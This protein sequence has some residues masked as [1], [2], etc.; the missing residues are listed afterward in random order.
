VETLE[1]VLEVGTGEPFRRLPWIKVAEN[2]KDQLRFGDYVAPVV[3]GDANDVDKHLIHI[4][5]GS[6][7]NRPSCHSVHEERLKML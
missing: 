6:D 5:E 1:E 4:E 7:R 3:I 2:G